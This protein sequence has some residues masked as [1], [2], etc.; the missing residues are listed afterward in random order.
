VRA[1]YASF[2]KAWEL[3]QRKDVRLHDVPDEEEDEDNKKDDDGDEEDGD[4]GYSE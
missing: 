1:E 3:A 4:E 2:S